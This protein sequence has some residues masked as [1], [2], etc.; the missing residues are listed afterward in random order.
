MTEDKR[1]KNT[2]QIKKLVT[3]GDS[4]T[5]G[6]NIDKLK[7]W[8]KLLHQKHNLEIINSG[9]SGDTTTGML[10]RFSE[11]VLAHKPS[12]L[13]IMGG[14]NDL[15][16]NLSISQVIANIHAMTR[17]AKFHG[18]ASIVGIPTPIITREN[19]SLDTYFVDDLNLTK[20]M[21]K[22]QKELKRYALEDGKEIVDFSGM[23]EALLLEDGVHPGEEGQVWMMEQWGRDGAR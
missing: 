1:S 7:R 6:Y 20:K 5:E 12:H 2:M 22:Y 11:D 16:L 8:T 17:Q 21:V 13:F 15:W 3:L 19:Y 18:I 14:T 4:L 10:S 23:D 9:I